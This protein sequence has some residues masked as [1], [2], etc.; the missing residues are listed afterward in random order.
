M[1]DLHR[2]VRAIE[3]ERQGAS[4]APSNHALKQQIFSL[5]AFENSLKRQLTSFVSET[6]AVAAHVGRSTRSTQLD[7]ACKA[8]ESRSTL[9]AT[10]EES[11]QKM[12]AVLSSLEAYLD[13]SIVCASDLLHVAPFPSQPP[14]A[15]C[16]SQ[17]P[18]QSQ[19]SH[20]PLA[21]RSSAPYQSPLPP[22]LQ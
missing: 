21:H 7:E 3:K 15:P 22:Q 10:T 6:A 20:A 19:P 4:K 2:G 12:P 14:Q 8:M 16:A 11:I 18:Q 1:S 13:E 5:V 9:M 17:P